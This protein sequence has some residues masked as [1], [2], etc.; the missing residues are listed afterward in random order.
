MNERKWAKYLETVLRFETDPPVS[1]DLRVPVPRHV[2]DAL[3]AISTDGCFAIVTASNPRGENV[4]DEENDRHTA[5]FEGELTESGERF[6]RVDACSPDGSHCERSIALEAT[7]ARAVEIA[8]RCDQLAVFW[9]D[10]AAF[11]IEPVLSKN[12]RLRL[13]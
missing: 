9:F 3:R 4:S 11:W 5:R 12:S 10:G 8:R 13:P 7:L 6:V 2:R 1:V